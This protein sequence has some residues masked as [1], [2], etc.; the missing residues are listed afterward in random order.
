MQ[1]ENFIKSSHASSEEDKSNS[2]E[3]DGSSEEDESS[4]E[5]NSQSSEWKVLLFHQ[6]KTVSQPAWEKDICTLDEF[7]EAYSHLAG[8]DFETVCNNIEE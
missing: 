8:L 5:F 4:Y 3:K 2:F 7:V 1:T 6:E